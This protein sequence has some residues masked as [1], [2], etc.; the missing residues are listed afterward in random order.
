MGFLTIFSDLY[1]YLLLKA[2]W[3]A[4]VNNKG[5]NQKDEF[6]CRRYPQFTRVDVKRQGA[7]IKVIEE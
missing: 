5:S 1:V 7:H 4:I 2:D 3:V 6:K